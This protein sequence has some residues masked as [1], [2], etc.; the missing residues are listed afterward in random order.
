MG[1]TAGLLVG[2]MAA[3]TLSATEGNDVMDKVEHCY[4][5]SGAVKIH[6]AK[7]GAGPPVVMVHGFP[8]FW[9]TWR[10]QMA[11]LSEHFTVAAPDLRGYNQSDKPEGVDNYDMPLL[12]GD[13]A[14]VVRDLGAEKTVL[15]GHDW[16]GAIAWQCAMLLPELIDKLIIVN[17]PHPKGLFRELAHNE[18]QRENAAY[19]RRFQVEGAHAVL[20]PEML[21]SYIVKDDEELKAKYIEAFR[22]SDFEAMLHY[23][24]KNYPREP[25]QE[26]GV[27]PPK[28]Q[29]PV[30][31]F[32]GLKD[33]ALHHHGL[34][35]TWEWLD[36]DYTL[37]TVPDAGHW[38]HRDAA[39]L[40]TT[41][42][43][44]WLLS[45]Q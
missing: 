33:W 5:D 32:H 36:Q 17:L 35:N 37:V 14:A 25:Y 3:G 26:L 1:T 44:W 31:Q 27:E 4:V 10:H 23:Y 38:V 22:N 42:I 20:T 24:K 30:L 6:Y 45:R 43:K 34:N 28:V 9:Y 21:T 8:D 12:V 18:E 39:E 19:A 13:V 11:A 41:T 2:V 16:G 15:V 40:V 29:C 7:L